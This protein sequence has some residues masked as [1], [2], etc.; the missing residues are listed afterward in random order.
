MKLSRSAID[1]P[2]L[3]VDIEALERNIATMAARAKAWGVALRPHAKT[4]KCSAIP[5]RQVAAGASGIACATIDEAEV[6]VEAELPG[7]LVTSPFATE[8]KVSRLMELAHRR[9]DL[10]VVA[11]HPQYVALLD[12]MARRSGVALSVLVDLDVGD[13]RT[14]A[15]TLDTALNLAQ[16]IQ[17]TRN[18]RFAGIQG[19]A[20]RIQHV[21]AF[22]KRSSEAAKVADQLAELRTR[23]E[24]LGL[25]P[26]VVTGGGTG[27]HAIDGPG[28]VFTEIQVGSYVL[29]D[30]EYANVALDEDGQNP[31]EPALFVQ[32]TVISSNQ[33][34]DF[35]TTDGGTKS[36]ALNGPP[37]QILSG[38]AA[39]CAYE[40][41]GDEHGRIN[42]KPGVRLSLGDRLECQPPHCDPTVCLYDRIVCVKGDEVVD[43]WPIDARGRR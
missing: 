23:L 7:V 31:F 8:H 22:A 21:A 27:T 37:P 9:P 33:Q 20:G 34:P 6:M 39:G 38:P 10:A 13:H 25:G 2:A 12:E 4:H 43:I 14:G 15:A 41:Q 42:L 11:D 30:A 36:F 24:L 40:F 5:R 3:L 35:V 19:Y 17:A 32:T 1:T 16:Q 29:M 18:L 28:G 26:S